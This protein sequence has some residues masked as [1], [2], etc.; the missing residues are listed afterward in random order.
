ME[1]LSNSLAAPIGLRP[2]LLWNLQFWS[3]SLLDIPKG[4]L[5]LISA[6]AFHELTTQIPHAVDVA[7]LG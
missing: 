6:L 1:I 2:F 3:P 4:V 7:I 5:C